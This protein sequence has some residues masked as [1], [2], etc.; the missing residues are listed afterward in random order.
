MFAL[1]NYWLR[2]FLAPSQRGLWELVKNLFVRRPNQFLG[3]SK[4][5]SLLSNKN[6]HTISEPIFGKSIR[7]WSWPIVF[8]SSELLSSRPKTNKHCVQKLRPIR[9][10]QTNF[11]GLS[12]IP[13]LISNKNWYKISEP[14]FGKSKK[15]WVLLIAFD[16]H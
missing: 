7:F 6:R 9:S 4:I 16:S 3:L 10:V 8:H 11:L 1:Q 14:I 5:P 12:K 13:S 15:F 2:Q